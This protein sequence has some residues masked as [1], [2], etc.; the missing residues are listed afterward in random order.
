MK[1]M[2][3]LL[4]FVMVMTALSA[5]GGNSAPDEPDKATMQKD[6]QEYITQVVDEEAEIVYF[7]VDDTD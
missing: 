1:K 5:C 7:S 3:V 2:L 6:V 4:L